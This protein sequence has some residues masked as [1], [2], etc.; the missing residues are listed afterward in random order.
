MYLPLAGVL[1]TD[2]LISVSAVTV[3]VIT[4]VVIITIISGAV[5]VIVI[6]T[7]P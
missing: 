5:F 6:T 1:F 3:I 2:R 4:A 7:W